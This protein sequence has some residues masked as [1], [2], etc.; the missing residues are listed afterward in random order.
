M[1][2]AYLLGPRRQCWLCARVGIPALAPMIFKAKSRE[3]LHTTLVAAPSF[4]ALT[5]SSI[6]DLVSLLNATLPDGSLD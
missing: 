4:V 2:A 1:V 3:K 5:R 6:M